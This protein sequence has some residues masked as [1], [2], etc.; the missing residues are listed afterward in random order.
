MEGDKDRDGDR[1]ARMAI[2]HA[3]IEVFF[4]HIIC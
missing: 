2:M 1:A 3:H 4:C